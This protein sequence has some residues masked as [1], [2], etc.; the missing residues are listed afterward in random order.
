[1]PPL[2]HLFE[3]S[4]SNLEELLH[5]CHLHLQMVTIIYVTPDFK[6]TYTQKCINNIAETQQ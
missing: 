2:S 3:A 1:M 4:S 6:Q 5:I